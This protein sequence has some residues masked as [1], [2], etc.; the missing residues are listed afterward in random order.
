M[1]RD[2]MQL[3]IFLL[4]ATGYIGQAFQRHLHGLK[5]PVQEITAREI[6]AGGKDVLRKKIREFHPDFLINAAGFTGKPNVDAAELMKAEALTGNVVFPLMVG[7]VCA[8]EHVPWGHVSSGCI[9]QGQRGT[10]AN[11]EA[12]GF[13]EEDPPNFD[14]NHLPSSFY[15]GTKSL[16]EQLLAGFPDLYI[17]R[18]RVPFD[19][20]DGARNYLSKLMRYPRLLDVRNS[21]SHRGEFVGACCDSFTRRLPY[22]VYNLTN[23]GSV[24]T[25]EVVRM[26]EEEGERRGQNGDSFSSKQMNKRYD[27]FASEI[28]F[29][30]Q[31]ARTPRSSCVLDTEKA[32]Q[33]GLPI[34]DVRT[35]LKEALQQWTWEG[36]V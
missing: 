31:A 14:F 26:I 20:R 22:G 32:K 18:L 13:R 7:E 10:G 5:V 36:R 33:E 25:R 4:G 24:T 15:S 28:E 17:W 1:I 6:L 12:L 35:A 29:M 3:M 19:E 34:R 11:G 21:L 8:E 27:F 30:Q 9:Y 2:S 16:A 23:H